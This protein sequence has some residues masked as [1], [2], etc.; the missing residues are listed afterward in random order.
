[1][2]RAIPNMIGMRLD[3]R[4]KQPFM[5]AQVRPKASSRRPRVGSLAARTCQGR[6]TRGQAPHLALT[7][8]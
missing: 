3:A 2:T 7:E 5:A 4:K 8:R 6:V 1:M